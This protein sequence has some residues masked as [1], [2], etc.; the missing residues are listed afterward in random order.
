MGLHGTHGDGG[1]W[2][3]PLSQ[4]WRH[5]FLGSCRPHVCWEGDSAALEGTEGA[6]PQTKNQDRRQTPRLG[7]IPGPTEKTAKP[8]AAPAETH[9]SNG[10]H[11]KTADSIEL[12]SPNRLVAFWASR[13][14]DACAPT[15]NEFYQGI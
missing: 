10:R 14:L 3:H 2:L 7:T 6:R 1:C 13:G 4:P 15:R 9:H 12:K 11:Q 8:I 5:P